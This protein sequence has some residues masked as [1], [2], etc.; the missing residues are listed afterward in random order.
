MKIEF[1]KVPQQEKEFLICEDLVKF[2]GTFCKISHKLIKLNTKIAGT[3]RV[4]CYRCGKEFDINLQEEQV[5]ILSDG[6]FN[7]ENERDDEIII[8]I[9][10]HLIDFNQ[11]LKSEI[12][13][14]KSD[15]YLCD[16]CNG[17]D[18]VIDIEY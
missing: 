11:I 3:Y 14:I 8:E 6:I 9:D 5:F 10:N 12:E 15:Y 1:K 18:S 2:S 4:D 7:S 16:S 17:D 13:S